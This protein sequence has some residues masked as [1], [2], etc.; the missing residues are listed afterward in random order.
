MP[1]AQHRDRKNNKHGLFSRT[2]NGSKPHQVTETT[3]TCHELSVY[4]VSGRKDN[5]QW[6]DSG[7]V[8]GSPR[9]VGGRASTADLQVCGGDHGDQG[10]H[11]V[12]RCLKQVRKSIL[13]CIFQR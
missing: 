8:G 11:E 5:K 7:N 2:N 1:D 10:I 4:R 13:H 6:L 9:V 3:V 12:W